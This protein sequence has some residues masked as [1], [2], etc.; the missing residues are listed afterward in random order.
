MVWGAIPDYDSR[1]IA[2]AVTVLLALFV[3]RAPWGIALVATAVIWEIAEKA[4]WFS[5][6]RRIPLAIGPETLV[7]RTVEVVAPCRPYG[8][9]RVRSERWNARCREGADVG[10]T[11]IVESME[12]LTLVVS[13]VRASST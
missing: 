1:V 11:V 9:V 5:S 4:F 2:I 8:T 12:W 6:T 13:S 10:D 3:I 7:G